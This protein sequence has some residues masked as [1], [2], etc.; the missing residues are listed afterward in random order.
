VRELFRAAPI[1]AR[2]VYS[3]EGEGA[4]AAVLDEVVARFPGV[5]VGSYPH[6]DAADYRV[7]I[8]LDGRD[9]AA[10]DAAAAAL[11]SGLGAAVVRF[12]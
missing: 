2:A 1:H 8:T 6:L 3:R 9:R 10:V 12:E 4:I 5:D 11:V 7:K